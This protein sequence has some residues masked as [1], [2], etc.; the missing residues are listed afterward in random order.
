VPPPALDRADLLQHAEQNATLLVVEL[1][2]RGEIG[3][4]E[5]CPGHPAKDVSESSEGVV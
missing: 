4:R 3:V 1:R 5:L 2:Q